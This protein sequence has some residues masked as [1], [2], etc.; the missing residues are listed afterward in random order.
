MKLKNLPALVS[1]LAIGLATP[2]FAKEASAKSGASLTVV[3]GDDAKAALLELD[4]D[5]IQLDAAI[6]QAPNSADKVA[7]QA[8]LAGLK[9]RRSELRKT[10]VQ[11]RY[12]EL[13]ADVRTEVN[14]LGSGMKDNFTGVPAGK[15]GDKAHTKANSAAATIE[16]GAYKLRPTDT[17]REEAQAGL[18]ALEQKI[19]EL[20]A[21]ADRMPHGATRDVAQRRVQALE[22]RRV[23]LQREFN[24]VHFDTMI[25]DVHS[26]WTNLRD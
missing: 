26:E 6:D 24:K 7:A 16:L 3:K 21:R 4:T 15:A 18:Q 9:D 22:E 20:T 14:H 5:F 19:T 1:A 11:A 25:D 10:F 17:N 12:D 2:A 13:K 8:R 23:Q